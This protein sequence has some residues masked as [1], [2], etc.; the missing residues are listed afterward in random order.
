[1]TTAHAIVNLGSTERRS[2]TSAL[3][4]LFLRIEAWFEH[5]ASRRALYSVDDRGL[6]DLGLSRTDVDGF[7]RSPAWQDLL[8]VPAGR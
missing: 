5:R 6:A 4:P 1:M 8:I 3:L 7:D 2:L